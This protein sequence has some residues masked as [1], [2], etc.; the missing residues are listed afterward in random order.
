MKS[1]HLRRLVSLYPTA[2]LS[3]ICLVLRDGEA[4][5]L[6][7]VAVGVVDLGQVHKILVEYQPQI[8]FVERRR[9]EKH[10]PFP[11]P[12]LKYPPGPQIWLADDIWWDS[13][14]ALPAWLRGNVL[15]HGL[16]AYR[17]AISELQRHGL[18]SVFEGFK[19][20]QYSR[21]WMS[22]NR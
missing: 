1:R 3:G 7:G 14:E 16:Y 11:D 6:L 20:F 18:Y 17:L 19:V 12:P 21:Y 4:D 22:V 13:K 9:R 15:R 5:W 2:N 10:L 8:L